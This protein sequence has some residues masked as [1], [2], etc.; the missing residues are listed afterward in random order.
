MSKIRII[1][2]CHGCINKRNRLPDKPTYIELCEQLGPDDYSVQLG[3]MGFNYKGLNRLDHNRHVFIPGNH[4]NYT[5]LLNNEVPYSLGNYGMNGLGPFTF[6]IVRGA[7]S[8]DA[9]L[10]IRDE[11]LNGQKSWWIEEELNHTQGLNCLEHYER[12][13]PD[14]VMS[15]DCPYTV[16]K[17]IG[18]PDILLAFGFSINMTTS[19]QELMQ[20]MFDIHQPKLW[21][22]GHYHVNEKFRYHGTRFICVGER[23][24]IDFNENWEIIHE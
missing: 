11:K 1:G 12:F 8:I 17:M 7:F 4:D 18:N 5:Q 2:D 16:S 23:S 22:F 6:F 24:Y 19:S 21:L 14:V 20:Q 13:K 15:H 10:R 9:K 3:D